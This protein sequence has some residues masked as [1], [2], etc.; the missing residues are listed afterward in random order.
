MYSYAYEYAEPPFD[1]WED[2]EKQ[3]FIY[4]KI[5]EICEN[6]IKAGDKTLYPHAFDSLYL[7]I[8]QHIEKFLPEV[9]HD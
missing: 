9:C 4:E 1:E 3:V 5:E 8:E 2:R 7:H 6:I